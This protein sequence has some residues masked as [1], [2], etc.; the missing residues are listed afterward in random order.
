M[1]E[2]ENS[3][4]ADAV[5]AVRDSHDDYLG[6]AVAAGEGDLDQLREHTDEIRD[7]LDTVEALVADATEGDA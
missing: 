1:A 6:L 5:D 3:K 4:R 2:L 7:T